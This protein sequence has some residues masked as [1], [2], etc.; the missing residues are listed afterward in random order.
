MIEELLLIKDILVDIFNVKQKKQV[1]WVSVSDKWKK[2]NIINSCKIIDLKGKVFTACEVDIK[3]GYNTALYFPE[4]RNEISGRWNQFNKVVGTYNNVSRE[5]FWRV[6]NENKQKRPKNKPA[7][8]EATLSAAEKR[9]E[10]VLLDTKIREC[11]EETEIKLL[12]LINAIPKVTFDLD[13]FK[14]EIITSGD[15]D[16][17]SMIPKIVDIHKYTFPLNSS[18]FNLIS[19]SI[20]V[21]KKPK[22]KKDD[23]ALDW[24]SMLIGYTS[25]YTTLK[26]SNSLVDCLIDFNPF[27]S[28]EKSSLLSSPSYKKL[29]VKKLYNDYK[30][31]LYKLDKLKNIC[32]QL[33]IPYKAILNAGFGKGKYESKV[34]L[35]LHDAKLKVSS[36]ETLET[37][38]DI[39]NWLYIK[40]TEI[41][42]FLIEQYE[43]IKHQINKL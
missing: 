10:L 30:K 41:D 12:E 7:F 32:K 21:D 27:S 11:S 9:K 31:E 43:Y 26:Q 13:T 39:S 40:Q 29:Q 25:K 2:V 34:L 18:I 14:C 6:T 22:I 20:K 24:Q 42:S 36:Y 35:T 38:Y 17:S 15:M 1:T 3:D 37:A 23:Q 8:V 33:E 19:N 4:L 5:D 16:K 28:Y